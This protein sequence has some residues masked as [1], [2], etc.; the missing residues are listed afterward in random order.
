M[1]NNPS[2]GGEELRQPD[3]RP[4]EMPITTAQETP[5]EAVSES[6]SSPDPMENT[7]ANSIANNG[8]AD[9]VS[10][11]F[12]ADA[13]AVESSQ[14]PVSDPV[15][16]NADVSSDSL[17]ESSN[18]DSAVAVEE[19]TNGSVSGAMPE[20]SDPAAEVGQGNTE[21]STAIA[22]ERMS[23][24][25][26]V[27]SDA[28]SDMQTL[29]DQQPSSNGLRKGDLVEGTIIST[30]PTEI[31]VDIGAKTDA[32]VNGK[33]LERLT[34]E[35]LQTLDVG[36]QIK[37]Y[38]LLPENADGFPVLSLSRAMEEQD[39]AR[40][41]ELRNSKEV[42]QGRIDGY[43]RGGLIVRFGRLRGFVPESQ[44]SR[45]RRRRVE[46]IT[47]PQQKW[48]KMRNEEIAVKVL[49]VDRGRDRLILSEREAVPALRDGQKQKLLEELKIGDRRTGI[50][51][52][53]TEFGAFVDVGG[54][55][56]LVHITEISHKHITSPK[57][58]L[59]PGQ[60]VNVEVISVD[61]E[62][63]RIGLSIK[64][65]ESDPWETI[66]KKYAVG[67]LVEGTITKTAKFGA[68]ARLKD[69]PEIE[70]LIHLSE[71]ADH[72]VENPNEVVNEGEEYTLR[73]VRIDPEQRRIALSIKKVM[74]KG[75]TEY[76]MRKATGM[77]VAGFE[78]SSLRE[79]GRRG[80]GGGGGGGGNYGGGSGGGGGGGG[81]GRR[82]DRKG[83]R[84]DNEY[85]D[86]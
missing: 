63:K 33:E 71:L 29:L 22:N 57:D 76:D 59:K 8:G 46:G 14:M 65:T 51:K 7:I 42:Y 1:S 85:D 47:D 68:F 11:T 61:P 5:I 4:D 49:E 53:V 6:D 26:N 20:V 56:G 84:R 55:D 66:V 75:F 37:A 67:Q 80:G 82:R 39:W 32:V 19:S 70:G 21:Q 43:N 64:R 34:P 27:Q 36:K 52:S 60:E 40:A 9:S 81:G 58:V 18:E 48:G 44:V 12:A 17:S 72:H 54:A 28:P 10:D 77:D 24:D 79:D 23:D 3:Q 15:L 45:D 86:E 2:S 73:I 69:D 38:I 35:T 83:R 31:R 25:G 74:D 16:P 62:R 78:A 13:P 30:S 50:I 41:E